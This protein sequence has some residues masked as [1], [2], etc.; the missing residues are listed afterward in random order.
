[1]AKYGI[2]ESDMWNF[3]E[4]GFMMGVISSAMVVTTSDRQGRAKMRQPGNRE[5]T[6]VI[7]GVNSYGWA[8][9]PFIVVSGKNHLASWY[10]DSPLP[11]DW[12]ISLSS[13]GWT[14]NEIGLEW[15][16]HFNKHTSDR[17]KGAY[18]LLVLDGHESH[19]SA[20][21]QC[22]CKENK[23]VTLCMPA[24]SSHLLQPLDVGCFGPLKRSYG[25][26]IEDLMR[27]HI[28]HITKVEFFAAFKNAFMA[29]FSEANVRGGFQGAGLVPFNPETVLSKLDVAP[30]TP[31]PTGP[32]PATTDP[33]TSRTPQ[34]AYE[35]SSQAEFI[36]NRIAKHQDSSP[37]AIYGAMDQLAKSTTA[38]MH[39][40][41]LM[42]DRIINLEKANHTLSKRRREKKTRIR[43]GGSLTVR[44][45]TEL[46]NGREAGGQLSEEMHTIT[47]QVVPAERK[48]RR[49]GN[50]G[51]PGHNVRTCQEDVESSSEPDSS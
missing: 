31:T 9:P 17:T 45:A 16:K 40:L 3:D 14:T 29:S 24:H 47:G 19:V 43:Q 1:M 30:R 48:E 28:S 20:D 12:V 11:A 39:K 51:N 5:W 2:D 33:W 13:N 4:T 15:I 21:F 35:A 6:T 23:I 41:V 32:P 49:C 50:C 36:K 46:L 25:K 38:V 42:H 7:Q 10:R 37:T 22:Y 8:I 27:V 26:E 18:R 44:E 34:N